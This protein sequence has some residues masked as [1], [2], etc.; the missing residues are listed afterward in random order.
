MFASL[1][2]VFSMLAVRNVLR[3]LLLQAF[4]SIWAILACSVSFSVR[5][6]FWSVVARGAYVRPA[7][8]HIIAGVCNSH[9]FVIVVVW[10]SV[11][12]TECF[13][14]PSLPSPWEESL[15]T[16]CWLFIPYFCWAWVHFHGCY[17]GNLAWKLV[18]ELRV[19]QA[20]GCSAAVGYDRGHSPQS[21]SELVM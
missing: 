21:P 6:V 13:Y 10:C 11:L 7:V 12:R 4:V 20:S 16:G 19:V 15:V 18:A 1:S 2:S 9:V 8:V 5:R 3:R 17:L 14:V